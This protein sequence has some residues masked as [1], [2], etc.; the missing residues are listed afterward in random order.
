VTTVDRTV[1]VRTLLSVTRC[2]VNVAVLSAGPAS[3][4]MI[5]V[6]RERTDRTVHCRV[7]VRT[8]RPV[9]S[10]LDAASVVQAGTANT[11]N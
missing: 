4:V 7:T 6:H 10:S 1:R 2:P 11:A 5:R 3:A 9:M 8:Q